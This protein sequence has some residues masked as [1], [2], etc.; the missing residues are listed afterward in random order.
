MHSNLRNRFSN[1]S[2]RKPEP[3]KLEEMLVELLEESTLDINYLVLIVGSC[4]IATFGLLS[5]SAA[6]IIGAM[7]VCFPDVANLGASIC[8]ISRQRCF[9]S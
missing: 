4:A 3:Q 9:F 6:V 5:N 2:R 1:L 8:G 7:I